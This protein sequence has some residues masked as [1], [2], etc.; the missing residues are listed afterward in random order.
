MLHLHLGDR[1]TL[2]TETGLG[3]AQR[4]VTVVVVGTFR[5]SSRA[6]WE[7][8]PLS[9]AGFE[10]AYSDGS[11]TAPTYGPFMVGRR[12]V[13]RHRIQRRP[14]C[15]WTPTP[16]LRRRDDASL[17]AAA[18]SLGSASGL[19]SDR[20][21]GSARIT[22]VASELPETLAGSTR[23]RPPPAPRC[24]S[25]CCWARRWPWP[26]C[27]WRAGWS[28]TSARDEREL[29]TA[30]GL[31]RGQQLVA[32]LLEAALLARG[33]RPGGSGRGLGAL[34]DDPPAGPRGRRAGPG[35]DRH[36]RAWW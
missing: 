29:L 11:V 10:P 7:S 9:G 28:P 30:L 36:D 15:G 27:C 35:P 17:S 14:D 23:S 33:G 6:A 5:P 3:G 12:R 18:V 31:G 13:P 26:R 34:A 25:S 21:G 8:D 16:I 1:V 19:L 22:R 20:V 32:A 4:P 2:G 24:W